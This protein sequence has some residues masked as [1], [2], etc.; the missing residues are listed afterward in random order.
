MYTSP[1]L[2]SKLSGGSLS[3]GH[4]GSDQNNPPG[5]THG[6]NENG[7]TEEALQRS[8]EELAALQREYEELSDSVEPIIWK[9]EA[10]PLRFTFISHQAETLRPHFEHKDNSRRNS[11]RGGERGASDTAAGD[12]V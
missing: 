1:P 5:N 8:E 9:E 12:G 6:A 11:R 10:R 3:V 7:Q 4:L 2:V